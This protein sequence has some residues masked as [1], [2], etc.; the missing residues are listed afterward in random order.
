MLKF[1]G[2]VAQSPLVP[3]Q[4]RTRLAERSAWI[5]GRTRR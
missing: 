2:T 4:L 1:E 3:D 5:D